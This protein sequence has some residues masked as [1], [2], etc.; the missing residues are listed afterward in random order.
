MG[1]KPANA[2]GMIET[3]NIFERKAISA[4]K[5]NMTLAELSMISGL[6]DIEAMRALQWLENRGVLK[7][8]SQEKIG[9]KIGE[10]GIRYLK[11]GFPEKKMLK[12]I[13]EMPCSFDDIKSKLNMSSEEFNVCLGMLKSRACILIKGNIIEITAQGK[14]ILEK[15]S[16]EEKFLMKLSA[17]AEK[18]IE[19]R[20]LGPEEKFAFNVLKKRKDIIKEDRI[21]KKSAVLTDLGR[22]LQRSNIWKMDRS[23]M[24]DGLTPDMLSMGSWKNKKFRRY[25]LNGNVPAIRGGKRHFVNQTSENIKSIWLDMG[26]KEMKGPML[27]TSF[28]NF[29]AL[30]TAQD[31]PVRELQ[32][33][34]YI[35]NP[36]KG[37]LPDKKLVDAVKAMHEYGGNIGSKGWGYKWDPEEAKKNVLRTHTTILS[38]K[39]IA[40]LKKEDLP[41]KFFS[42]AKCFRNEALDWKHL[43][44]LNQVEGIV[45]DPDA[46]FRNLLWY[47]KEFFKKLGYKNVRIRPAYFPYTEPSAEIEAFHPVKKQWV[48]LGGA[49]IFRPEVVAPLLGKDI[50]VL[51]WGMGLERSISEFFKISDIR[52]LYTNDLKQLREMKI[53]R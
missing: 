53:W 44:E 50:P 34:F 21:K 4:L 3:L 46:N 5:D 16:L 38:A 9:I 40:G 14:I 31:H 2:A 32:D 1:T 25:D 33:T 11:E 13:R 15:E 27:D 23:D 37:R 36:V 22:E 20:D 35:K 30:F 6:K 7:I 18:G 52:Q 39:T 47:L 48:E 26:F 12:L 10:N 42:V 28:W 24:I 45:V 41:A 49:G 29:D 19:E 8:D 43:F 51:A 17:N